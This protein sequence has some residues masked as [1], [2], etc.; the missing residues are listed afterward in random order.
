MDEGETNADNTA[1]KLKKAAM[2]FHKGR[3][4]ED[5]GRLNTGEL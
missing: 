2:R 1:K 5:D 3:A 4:E